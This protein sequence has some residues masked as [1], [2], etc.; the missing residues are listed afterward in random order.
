VTP[1]PHG[2][3]VASIA[4]SSCSIEIRIHT[5]L[6]LVVLLPL[7]LIVFPFLTVHVGAS[8]INS[9]VS[10]DWLHWEHRAPQPD[11]TL[12]SDGQELL[13]SSA[14]TFCILTSTA[15]KYVISRKQGEAVTK[16][17]RYQSLRGAKGK[18]LLKS[19]RGA[20]V[21]NCTPVHS[22]SRS[23]LVRQFDSR[24]ARDESCWPFRDR[25]QYRIVGV[26]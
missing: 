2:D 20:L 24:G 8:L 9:N 26:D 18:A 16:E 12:L 21:A 4:A 19:S 13:L 11:Y 23:S 22:C 7:V 25:A 10:Q 3:R 15:S 14:V 1:G 5:F 17:R 6:L